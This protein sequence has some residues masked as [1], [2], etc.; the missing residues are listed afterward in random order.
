MQCETCP[1]RRSLRQLR[2]GIEDTYM[3]GPWLQDSIRREA[4]T[5]LRAREILGVD[6]DASPDD[7]KRAWRKGCFETHP[8]RNPGDRG[9]AERFRI[10][11]CAYQFLA[12]GTPCNELLDVGKDL[13]KA[14]NRGKYNLGNPWGYY[15]W[16]RDSFLF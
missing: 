15:L 13:E 11:N 9:A 2:E 10:A 14:P 7:I 16:W 3:C 12:N 6:G 1:F 4:E 8:D 5:E